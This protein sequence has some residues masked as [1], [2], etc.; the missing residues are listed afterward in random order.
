[1]LTMLQ[2]KGEAQK[3]WAVRQGKK[4]EIH[5]HLLRIIHLEIS[6]QN[7][8]LVLSCESHPKCKLKATDNCIKRTLCKVKNP[9]TRKYKHRCFIP[10]G[11]NTSPSLMFLTQA[12]HQGAEPT[13]KHNAPSWSC[14][15]L[16]GQSKILQRRTC[17][18]LLKN[19]N[20]KENQI[21]YSSQSERSLIIHQIPANLA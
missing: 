7:I 8:S 21:Y 5:L 17:K 2:K 1:M 16:L 14:N 4:T 15:K 18:N 6:T 11:N 9:C 10:G 19:T 12:R 20:I 13:I 3:K